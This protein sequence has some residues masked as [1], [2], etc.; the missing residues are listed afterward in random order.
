MFTNFIHLEWVFAILGKHLN[1][2]IIILYDYKF[3]D[4][5]G[6]K[7]IFF[8]MVKIWFRNSTVAVHLGNLLNN[9]ITIIKKEN[10]AYKH[11]NFVKRH[12]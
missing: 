10:Y 2:L 3:G 1:Y 6:N 11:R 7:T 9:F 5:W 8:I 12:D 4:S